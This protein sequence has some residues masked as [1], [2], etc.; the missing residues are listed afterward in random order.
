M[1]RQSAVV[2]CPGRGT[3]NKTEL[4]YLRRYHSDKTDFIG[5]L[6]NHRR[7]QSQ[8]PV[9]QLDAS[10][11][12][13]SEQITSSENASPL[14]YGCAL[15]DFQAIDRS[16]YDI[17]AIT[18]NSMG[19]YLALA[20]AGVLT[21]E[22]GMQ[23][24]NTMGTLMQQQGVGGQVIYPLV[25]ADWQ[26]DTQLQANMANALA[27]AKAQPQV[28][29]YNSIY[30]G[31]MRVLA[32]NP[33]GMDYLLQTLP[34]VQER[35]PMPLYN[36]GAFH[37][38]LM[39]HIPASARSLLA[40]T[41]FKAPQIPLVDGCGTIWQP[42]SAAVAD[43]YRYTFGHQ[44]TRSYDFSAA[45]DVAVKEFAPDKL[46]LLGP[47]TTLGAPVAQQ[48]IRHKWQG[49]T[50]KQGFVERQS[51]QPL[52]LAMGQPEQRSRVLPPGTQ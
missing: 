22:G 29:V 15:G 49:L 28:E 51:Q 16:R 18:G 34:P 43:M 9:S 27:G 45:I 19:W 31:G 20:C 23:V 30:L 8:Q 52:L 46:I 42:W 11:R 5:M 35:Y 40:D 47:G 48:L 38:P 10:D 44:L 14:I 37:S 3:Y 17:V 24:V 12:F 39:A 13:C 4:G 26:P 25:G 32:A 21:L 36:H 7:Q 33:A 41:L 50:G 2:I 1:S 6:D